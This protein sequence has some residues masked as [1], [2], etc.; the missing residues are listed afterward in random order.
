VRK[1][2]EI[3]ITGGGTREP[4][5]AVRWIGNVSTGRMAVAVARA[6]ARRQ[7]RVRLFLA[8]LSPAPRSRRIR[9]ERFVTSADLRERLQAATPRPDVIVHAAAVSD[10]APAP[11]RGKVPSGKASWR[12][13]LRPQPKIAVDLRR[14]HPRAVLCTF[15]LET[16]VTT[17]ELARRA[18]TS[19]AQAGADLVFANRLED[20]GAGHRGLL[21]DPAT[22][23]IAAV[24]TREAAA[25][26]ILAACR[27]RLPLAAAAKGGSR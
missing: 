8:A 9:V 16:G 5:D 6:A 14:R 7:D 13:V 25:R 22:G 17:A 10:Y 2:L 18:A 11:Q 23:P 15:K 24:R 27:A 1:P 12:V 19:A 21:I 4:I 26:A 20:V 3:W